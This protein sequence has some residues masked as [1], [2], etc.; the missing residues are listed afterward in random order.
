M[1]PLDF[2]TQEELLRF[3][4]CKKTEMSCIE[5]PHTFLNQLRDHNLVPEDLYKKVMRTRSK[6]QREKSFYRVLDW[7]E[8]ERPHFIKLFWNCV[9][10][11]HILLLYP[12]IRQLKSNLLDGSFRF[13]EDLP[14]KEAT[15]EECREEEKKKTEVKKSEEKRGKK[16][17]ESTEE[18]EEEEEEAG[19]STQSTPS[20]RKKLQKLSYSSPISKGVKEDIW[21]W[22]L[23]KKVL[24]VTCGNKEGSLY[25]DKLAK[26]EKCILAEG[27]WF[28]P[29]AF[30]EF[31]GKK[32]SKNWKMSIRCQD[33][34]C[35]N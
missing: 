33:T 8:T 24:P 11:D 18:E 22:P 21:T 10:K 2:L 15:S 6:L 3:F 26:G 20:K 31:G 19:P 34:P 16:R 13:A 25:R 28:T 32:S 27:R 7:L 29:S 12:V 17:S 14:E 4:H 5:Q 9:F 35:R 1:D 23:Y 30:E